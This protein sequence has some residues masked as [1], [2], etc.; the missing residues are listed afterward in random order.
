MEY[1][2]LGKTGLWVSKLAMG[3]MTFGGQ[4]SEADAIRY[5]DI[6][7]DAG[8]NLV[9]T[10]NSYTGGQSEII[11]GKALKGKRDK[12][13]LATKA[14]F[15]L[16]D[17]LN[18]K[19]LS[20]RFV[21]EQVEKSLKRLDTD[22]IDIYFMHLPDHVTAIEDALETYSDLVHSGKIRYIGMSNFA[23]WRVCEALWKAE[24]NHLYPPVLTEMVLNPITRGLET[25]FIPFVQEHNLGLLAYNPLAGGILSGKYKKGCE[26]PEDS[27]YAKLKAY[28]P[29]YW[30]DDNF[31]AVEE[32]TAV[33]NDFGMTPVELCMSWVAYHDGVT[34]V[35]M[36]FSKEAQ[37][38]SNLKSIDRGPL[39]QEACARLDEIWKSISG[40]R[41]SYSR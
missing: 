26:I 34:S 9:D 36:G 24:A 40:N 2:T 21:M 27:R 18:E 22:Y 3:T 7:L 23:A 29:R 8:V 37:L 20:R 13:I 11:V 41:F 1:K 38:M 17:G 14:G 19:G 15:K 35:L 33:A 10:A 5:T 25:E 28:A 31:D 4:V 12:V 32:I 6:A 39:P 30:T 16:G